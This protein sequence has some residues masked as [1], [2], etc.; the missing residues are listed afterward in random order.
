[1][2]LKS[3]IRRFGTSLTALVT[4]ALA[5]AVVSKATQTFTVPNAA[6]FT[7][8]L[9]SGAYSSPITPVTNQAVFMMG[10]QTA[11]GYRGVA[12]ATILHIPSSFIEWVGLESPASGAVTQGFSGTAGTHVLWLDYSEQVDVEVASADTIYIHNGASGT[13]TGNLELIW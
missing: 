1:M 12:S 8:S 11:P 5:V 13:R 10:T 9:D 4:I 7:Y 3:K 2:Q 6:T